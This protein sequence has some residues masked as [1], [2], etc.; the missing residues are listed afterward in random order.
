M[1]CRTARRLIGCYH[2]SR[3]NTNTGKLTAKMM[4]GVRAP[5]DECSTL[6]RTSAKPL[7]VSDPCY[8]GTVTVV[9]FDLELPKASEHV[10]VIV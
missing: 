3:Q 10:A 2:P 5:P 6:R 4:D 1:S 7:T 9:L 8:F